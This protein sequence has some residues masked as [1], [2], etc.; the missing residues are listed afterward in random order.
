MLRVDWFS[1]FLLLNNLLIFVY[2]FH[3]NVLSDP[4]IHVNPLNSQLNP[5]CQSQ[6]AELF[7]GHLN[8]AHGFRKTWIFRELRGINLW[9]KRNKKHFVR[10]ETDTAQCAFKCC[11]AT[12]VDVSRLTVYI[13]SKYW[14]G[15]NSP[16]AK[17]VEVTR[18]L[19]QEFIM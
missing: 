4:F 15:A 19:L 14:L 5:I 17:R 3:Y 13:L 1:T 12:I 9:N 18:I 7:C 10:K 6:L 16:Q 8:F 11:N 2:Q